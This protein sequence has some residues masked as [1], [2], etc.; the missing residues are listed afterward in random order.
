LFTSKRGLLA[1]CSPSDPARDGQEPT[2]LKALPPFILAR[3]LHAI[4]LGKRRV[5]DLLHSGGFSRSCH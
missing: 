5:V 4:K 1:N 2:I 3:C